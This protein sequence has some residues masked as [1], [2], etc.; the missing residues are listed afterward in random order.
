MCQVVISITEVGGRVGVGC[1]GRTV[2]P[3]ELKTRQCISDAVVDPRDMLQED[4]E[5]PRG[6]YD[7]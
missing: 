2:K 4:S 1:W 5:V 7:E 3:V 6:S